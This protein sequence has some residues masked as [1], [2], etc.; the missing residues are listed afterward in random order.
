[1]YTTCQ[2]NERAILQ[3]S[4]GWNNFMDTLLNN[5]FFN[6]CDSALDVEKY[7]AMVKDF[8]LNSQT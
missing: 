7:G 8:N 4:P 1:M 6:R 2:F 5:T 3:P